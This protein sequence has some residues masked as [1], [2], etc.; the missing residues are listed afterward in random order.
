MASRS[1]SAEIYFLCLI[2]G[3]SE[4]PEAVRGRELAGDLKRLAKIAESGGSPADEAWAEDFTKHLM[5]MARD[6]INTV[7]KIYHESGI[8]CKCSISL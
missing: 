3:A 7:A 5:E 8:E 1:E 4:D 2:Y 6:D